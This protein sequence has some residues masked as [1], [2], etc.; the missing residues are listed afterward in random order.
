MSSNSRSHSATKFYQQ[1]IVQKISS[2]NSTGIVLRCWHDAEDVPLP[3]PLQDPLMR[4]LEHGEVGVSF[5]S[6]AADKREILPEL[7][8]KLMDRSLQPGDVVKR[9][10][11]DVQSAIVLDV[12]VKARLEHAVSKEPVEGWK[13]LEDLN[14]D[15]Q[16]EIGDYVV[17]DDWLGQV[18]ELYDENIVEIPSGQLVR[19]PE[20]GSRLSVGEKGENILPSP[21]GGVQN[22]L[23]FF[24][25]NNRSSGPQ[26]VISIKHTVY[27]IAWLAL[28]QT[29]ENAVAESRH[30]PQRFWYG[31]DIAKLTLIRT[32]LDFQ[33]RIGER[34]QLKNTEGLPSTKHG[35]EGEAGGVVTVDS[36]NVTATETEVDILWQDGHRETVRSVDVIPYLNP[37]EY[38]CWPGD[39]VYFLDHGG[40]KHA[41]G[42]V[43]T[44]D[45]AQRTATIMLGHDRM[46]QVSLL[47]LD[48]QG[49][50]NSASFH[51]GLG[52]RRGETV[53][54]H[55]PGKSNGFEVPRVPRIGEIEHWVRSNPFSQSG[56]LDG[57]RAELASIGADIAT[58]RG[59]EV[60]EEGTIQSLPPVGTFLWL[61]E[62]T[63]LRLDGFVEVL[64]P[65]GTSMSYPLGRLTR[66]YDGIEQLED[67]FYENGSE[68]EQHLHGIWDY[69]YHWGPDDEP[70]DHEE[71][72]DEDDKDDLNIGEADRHSLSASPTTILSMSS[73]SSNSVTPDSTQPILELAIEEEITL[74][75]TGSKKDDNWENFKILTSAPPDHAYSQTTAAQP[76]RQFMSRLNREYRILMS[77]LPENILV[78]VYEDRADLLRSLIIGPENTPYEHA[79]FVIDWHL[80]DYP[81]SPPIAHFHSQTNGNGRVNPNL[82][83]EGKV[84]LSIL[85]TWSGDRNESWD[86]SRSSLLQALVSIQGLVLVREPWFCEPAFE[87]LRGTEEGIVNSRLYSEKAYVLS[88][89]FVRRTLE[90]PFGDLE[91]EINWLYYSNNLLEKVLSDSRSLISASRQQSLE[92]ATEDRAIPKLSVGGQ[93][94]LERT[95]I[96]LQNLLDNHRSKSI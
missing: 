21:G 47:E 68:G 86:A 65:E 81:H 78:R 43:Q 85:N 18:I 62:V 51:E 58:R 40:E 52:V 91:S 46:E 33:M 24:F 2:P 70:Y 57:W 12:R 61:G 41:P 79:P 8:L 92:E 38:D 20:I 88:R 77:S 59:V 48:P 63:D 95:L 67:E 56:Q 60:L 19:L 53:F 10:I 22:M 28:N 5:L 11:E 7:D 84:C 42:V 23:S 64:H 25:G 26:T 80:V 54:I 93:I 35:R 1:D 30:R 44:V 83:E 55:P 50:S 49:A 82:Y 32:R 9:R 87:K 15:R 34:V 66:L 75:E 73:S 69:D 31:P 17:Y 76:S 71:V 13:S 89:G 37:D 39:H 36:F 6:G 90:T 16:A 29:L 45:A 4:P 27:A 94:A 96:A 14:T 3:N 74:E 72:E